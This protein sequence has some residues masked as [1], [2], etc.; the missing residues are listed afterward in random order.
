MVD[1]EKKESGGV[2]LFGDEPYVIDDKFIIELDMEREEL[3]LETREQLDALHRIVKYKN[4]LVEVE[5]ED[6]EKG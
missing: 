3:L 1:E 6:E 2:K 4:E 5:E